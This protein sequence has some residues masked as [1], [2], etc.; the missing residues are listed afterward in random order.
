MI[1]YNRKT[2]NIYLYTGMDNGIN[3]GSGGTGKA[4]GIG[5]KKLMFAIVI[6][7][8][9]TISFGLGYLANREFSHAPIVIQKGG[10]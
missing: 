7:L 8:V 3:E 4:M 10:E 6:F 9:A 5:Q 1:C 2:V